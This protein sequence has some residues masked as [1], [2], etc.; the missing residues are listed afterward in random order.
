MAT[1]MSFLIYLGNV[2]SASPEN[3]LFHPSAIRYVAIRQS[4][5]NYSPNAAFDLIK[6]V[7]LS[8]SPLSQSASTLPIIY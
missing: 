7:A 3:F 8:K 4:N 1:E 2:W 5:N 6:T